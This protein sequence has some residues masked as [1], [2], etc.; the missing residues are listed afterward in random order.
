MFNVH[1]QCRLIEN[2]AYHCLIDWID[3]D[4][5]EYKF[6]KNCPKEEVITAIEY[7]SRVLGAPKYGAG[8]K[9]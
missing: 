4:G 7:L 3:E 5:K 8:I 9:W 1:Y 6:E 2:D